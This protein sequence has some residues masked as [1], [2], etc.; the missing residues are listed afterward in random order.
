MHSAQRVILAVVSKDGGPLTGI[1][2]CFT[3][4]RVNES[5][6]ALDCD[7]DLL[8][9]QGFHVVFGRRGVAVPSRF[10][11]H[12]QKDSE[13]LNFERKTKN[14]SVSVLGVYHELFDALHRRF[15]GGD[16]ENDTE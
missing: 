1:P 4:M 12:K 3:E 14:F 13:T 9:E 6:T 8:T 15:G 7:G 11:R 10:L 2:E 5:F 16:E